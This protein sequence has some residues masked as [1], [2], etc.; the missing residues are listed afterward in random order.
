MLTLDSVPCSQLDSYCQT[1][2]SRRLLCEEPLQ[3]LVEQFQPTSL[4]ELN[5]TAEML[6]RRDNKYVVRESVLRKIFAKLTVYFV[7][8]EING[9]RIFTYETCYFDDIERTNYFD[10]HRHRRQRCKV[11]IRRYTD[12]NS[13]FVEVKLKDKRDI[14]VKKRL[15][16]P[17]NKYGEL[18]ESAWSHIKSC[19]RELYGHTFDRAL[20]P[21]I[22]MRYQRMT[23]VAKQGNER[24]T[25]DFALVFNGTSNMR[26]VDENLFI[27]ETK[28][29]NGNGIADKILREFHQH[30]TQRCSKYCLG[31]AAL[32]E[33]TKHNNFLVAL[34]K[35]DIVPS[36][37]R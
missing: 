2:L 34:R 1:E 22:N 31:M 6:Q 9:K 5:A 14:T 36:S 12:N 18:D 26:A 27:I 24:M 13:C 23:L 8:L 25:V 29:S 21:V 28:S 4:G 15:A 32:R 10:H 35:L 11:R 7:I 37:R 30:H 17:P 19:Y 20:K 3:L 16:Y 33:V